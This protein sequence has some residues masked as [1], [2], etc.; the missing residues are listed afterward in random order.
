MREWL[1]LGAPRNHAAPLRSREWFGLAAAEMAGGGHGGQG[2]SPAA[3]VAGR[4]GARCSGAV[5]SWSPWGC[6]G[7]A[8]ADGLISWLAAKKGR[9]PRQAPAPGKSRHPPAALARNSSIQILCLSW[10]ISPATDGVASGTWKAER[11]AREKASRW[12]GARALSRSCSA[13]MAVGSRGASGPDAWLVG[14]LVGALVA[15]SCSPFPLGGPLKAAELAWR[16]EC[17]TPARRR[18]G[19]AAGWQGE[20]LAE[21]AWQWRAGQL[22][23]PPGMRL[24]EPVA[25]VE[26]IPFAPRSPEP[27]SCHRAPGQRDC[28]RSPGP[29]WWHRFRPP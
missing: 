6:A 12:P 25:A 9:G 5:G 29:V 4:F 20:P 22:P 13:A 14:A 1:V 16:E 11:K 10:R 17:H 3:A 19:L 27:G 18:G 23:A 7:P 2:C 24:E 8:V 15:D 28:Q 21:E 26:P